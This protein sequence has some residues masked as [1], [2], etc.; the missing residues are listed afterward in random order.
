M[1]IIVLIILAV[2]LI[3]IYGKTPMTI[4]SHPWN[5][6]YDNIQFS[7]KEFYTQVEDGLRARKVEGLDYAKESFLQSHLF[8]AR[9]EYLRITQSEYVFY[10]CAAPFGTGTFVS[11]WLCVKDEKIINKVPILSKF[12]GKDRNNKSFYQMDTEAMYQSVVHSTVV[13]VAD[14]MTEEKGLRLSELDRQYIKGN[15]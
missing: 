11:W 14:A 15:K 5:H 10:V 1:I 7:A 6:F 9:R 13:A 12:A 8:S 4:K 2:I 3:A